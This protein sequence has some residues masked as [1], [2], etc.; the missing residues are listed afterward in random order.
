MSEK[1][2]EKVGKL[3]PKQ[4]LFVEYYLGEANFNAR[5]AA[6]LA[7][8]K[9]SPRSLTSQGHELVNKPLVAEYIKQRLSEA[10]MSADEVLMRIGKQARAS[11]DDILDKNGR[12]DFHKVCEKGQ[13]LRHR[14]YFR[15]R[16]VQ[17]ARCP[18]P[19]R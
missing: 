17:R 5:K 7:G 12:F 2:K 18:R 4:I 10:A 16:D 15:S 19:S 13:I 8:Y 14:S 9:G 6:E 11:I 3:S 1:E